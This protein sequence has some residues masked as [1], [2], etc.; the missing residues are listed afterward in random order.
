MSVQH[1][2]RFSVRPTG[3]KG[4]LQ[5]HLSVEMDLSMKMASHIKMFLVEYI[6]KSNNRYFR[7]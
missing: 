3:M 1:E 4:G 2:E 5:T 6:I 7:M